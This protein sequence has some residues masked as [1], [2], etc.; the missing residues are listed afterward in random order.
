MSAPNTWVLDNN[1]LT[2]T[3]KAGVGDAVAEAIGRLKPHHVVA[4]VEHVPVEL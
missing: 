3:L 2:F 4:T 1:L